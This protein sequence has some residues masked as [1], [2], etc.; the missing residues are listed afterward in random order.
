MIG[1]I[2][3]DLVAFRT[4]ASVTDDGEEEIAI[5]RADRL[6]RELIHST[7]IDGY[8]C[9]ISGGDNFRKK[10]NPQYKANRT[11]EPP[12]FLQAC[13]EF[14][15]KEWNAVLA[16]GC[17]ADDLLGINQKIINDSYHSMML[18][19]QQQGCHESIIIS[20]DKDLLMI[21]GWHYSWEISG[22]GWT[23]EAQRTYT[24]PLDGIRTFYKQMLIGDVSDNIFGVRGI[25]KVKASKIL[26]EIEDEDEMI[27]IVHDLYDEDSERFL[28]NAQCLWIMQRE[29]E[30][31]VSRINQLTLPDLLKQ[32]VDAKYDYMISLMGD[33]SMEV[34]TTP[35]MTSGIPSSGHVMACTVQPEGILIL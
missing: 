2:D 11:T 29:G 24:T 15:V 12:K 16:N 17:E 5:L 31:W 27:E 1:N 10:V 21:P 3:G 22:A 33:T 26:D 28:M 23:K 32:E 18:E 6:M 35:Q 9:F 7:E 20:L 4:A 25:G 34:I 13:R 30:T 19:G 8:N 14:L